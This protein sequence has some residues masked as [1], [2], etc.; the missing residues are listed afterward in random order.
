MDV[1]VVNAGST[2]L[3][4]SLVRADGSIERVGD[5]V[6]ADAVGHRIVHMGDLA[7]GAALVEDWLLPY[8]EAG[9]LAAPLHNRPAIAALERARAALPNAPHV[10]VSDSE[11]HRTMPEEARRYAL[12]RDWREVVRL[13]FHGLA[14]ESVV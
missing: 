9:A 7:V 11:F 10:A 5:F 2:S 1:L 3:K 6:E 13:G 12:P 14:V 4:L 8:I